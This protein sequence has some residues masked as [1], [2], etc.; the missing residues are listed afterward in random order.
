MTPI[1]KSAFGPI[2]LLSL[3]IAAA[4]MAQ[5]ETAAPPCC[6]LFHQFKG[7]RY[8]KEPL[9]NSIRLERNGRPARRRG[10]AEYGTSSSSDRRYA[11]ARSGERTDSGGRPPPALW[12]WTDRDNADPSARSS[13]AATR[14]RRL[15]ARS[16]Q[17]ADCVSGDHGRREV[18]AGLVT[19]TTGRQP[20]G[21]ASGPSAFF[22]AAMPPSM[23]QVDVM[24]ASCAACTA[25]AE[26]S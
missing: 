4:T 8:C 19:V 7:Q 23:W 16:V 15:V 6:S 13:H 26:R 20:Q 24:P 11:H 10:K 2:L 14:A 18:T 3:T 21:R 9:Q 1:F 12:R 5:A 17:S 25:I 22:Q